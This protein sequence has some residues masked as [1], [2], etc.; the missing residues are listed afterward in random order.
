MIVCYFDTIC[1]TLNPLKN[2]FILVIDSDRVITLQLS[3]KF[4]ESVSRW[5]SELIER[6]DKID[7]VKFSG[8]M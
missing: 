3:G 8:C 1:I 2:D 4:F 5:N 6:Y 7:H